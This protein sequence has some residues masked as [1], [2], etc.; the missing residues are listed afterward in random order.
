[1]LRIIVCFGITACSVLLFPFKFLSYY[2]DINFFLLFCPILLSSLPYFTF[3][4]L[5]MIPVE[6]QVAPLFV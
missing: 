2:V 4:F 3:Y 5:T 1:M 6:Q